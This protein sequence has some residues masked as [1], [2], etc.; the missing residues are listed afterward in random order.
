MNRQVRAFSRRPGLGVVV[1]ALVLV[2]LVLGAVM[3]LSVDEAH[4][5]LYAAHPTLSYFDHPPLVGWVQMPL[6]A[7]DAPLALLRVLPGALWLGTVLLVYQL[8]GRLGHAGGGAPHRAGLWAVAA[9]ALAPLVHVLAIGLL[10]DTLLMFFVVLLMRQT[11]RLMQPDALCQTGPWLL[12]GLILGFAGLSKYTAIFFA[13]A[14]ALC[15]LQAHGL[16]VARVPAL[17]AA[18]ALAVL[19]VSP[20]LVWNARNGWVSF[21]YQAQHGAGS[22]WRL[23]DV[24]RFALVQLLA[25]GPLLCFGALAR[26]SAGAL[27]WFFVLPF[28]VLAWLSGGGSSLPHWTAPAWA[29][30]APFAGVA[31]ADFWGQGLDR[32]RLRRFFLG[33][34]VALQAMASAGLLWLMLSAGWPVLPR[35]ADDAPVGANPFVDVYGW[36]EAGTKAKALAAQQGL[37]SVSVQHWTLASRLGWYAQPLPVHDL[38]DR[39]DQFTL[40]AGPLPAGADTLLVDWSAMAY[41]VP[42]GEHGFDKCE[43]LATQVATHWGAPLSSFRFYACQGWSDKPQPRLRME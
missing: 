20:V 32:R 29:S 7:L 19:M 12:W 4:Y 41:A 23:Q 28:A 38:E 42:L 18:V 25:Y 3:G 6:V 1:G 14:S 36:Q 17:W 40:W 35:T 11:Q 13:L 30:L 21:V 22:V 15:L 37:G 8:A 31:L 5:L 39:V 24:L 27:R 26:T 34:W 33:A 10:P 16:R 43:L 2:H 9:L